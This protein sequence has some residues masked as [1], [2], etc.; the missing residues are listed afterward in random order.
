MTI[1]VLATILMATVPVEPP[2]TAASNA[3]R[4]AEEDGAISSIEDPITREEHRLDAAARAYRLDLPS[5]DRTRFW[6]TPSSKEIRAAAQT[7]G[8]RM[9]TLAD[10]TIGELL[11]LQTNS[12]PRLRDRAGLIAAVGNQVDQHAMNPDV[13]VEARL[14]AL[15]R[16]FGDAPTKL[17]RLD[18]PTLA[19]MAA[20]AASTGDTAAA[21]TLLDRSARD[22]IGLDALEVEFL[23]RCIIEGGIDAR[24]RAETA[25]R[26][27]DERIP[28]ADRMLL[29]AILLQARLDA[30]RPLP[31]IAGEV[32]RRL[33]PESGIEP[34]VRIAL[35]RR[36]ANLI[37]RQ[38]ADIPAVADLHPL[39][40][41]ARADRISEDQPTD[42]KKIDALLGRA[43]ESPVPSIRAEGLL[44]LA[45]RDMDAGRTGLATD[46]L[47]DLVE[48]LPS[49]PRAE[50]AA[51]LAIRLGAD[52][53]LAPLVRRLT[54]ALPEHPDRHRWTLEVGNQARDRGDPATARSTWLGIPTE[55]QERTEAVMRAVR[56][57]LETKRS[58][59]WSEDLSLLDGLELPEASIE[60][61]VARDLLRIELLLGLGR[62]DEAE[63]LAIALIER[64]A[65]P[66]SRVLQAAN[67][68]AKAM[69]TP[70]RR[71][72]AIRF[73]QRMADEHPSLSDALQRD[74]LER[75]VTQVVSYL[76]AD[77]REE[78]R[79]LAELTL[80][81][82][83]VD[84]QAL[85][86]TS[87][88]TVAALLGAAW[89]LASIDR[90]DEAIRLVEEALNREPDGLETLFLRAVL[91]GGR[92]RDD[93]RPT[94]QDARIALADLA[95]IAAGTSRGS[96]W[97]WRAE[98]E[99]LEI[100]VR[101][102]L[103]LSRVA[104]R[105]ERWR[106]QFPSLGG[107]EFSRRLRRLESMIATGT[108]D[109]VD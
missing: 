22:P 19:L 105:I 51:A 23:R 13:P 82:G 66:R 62:S 80:S 102:D 50:K 97:W 5:R 107:A 34:T 44:E 3:A 72:E 106:R 54:A 58:S 59:A 7:T 87:D 43:I 15:Q 6:W 77:R 69:T 75:A 45:V 36:L 49:H 67:T 90:H 96:I 39:A 1:F 35:L 12:G 84:P 65:L 109:R 85:A 57:D 26:M 88:T 93:R 11:G 33:L 95:R 92:L 79:S 61:R 52:G 68:V 24:R 47:L 32:R 17:S 8:R 38:S 29:A 40:A 56:I 37:E 86:G 48:T 30:G 94:E 81:R 71:D 2:A 104:N 91:Y 16:G 28:P 98:L 101:L 27:L 76:D 108:A 83:S 18:G 21:M 103:D 78:A 14:R 31:S 9:A 25:I 63:L 42:A 55:V 89:L 73:V 46:R 53:D 20:A 10:A 70:I 99:R 100:L 64:D 60:L 41:L 74:L 4:H